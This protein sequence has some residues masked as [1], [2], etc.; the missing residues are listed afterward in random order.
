MHKSYLHYNYLRLIQGIDLT[1]QKCYNLQ[2]VIKDSI[3]NSR[4]N[5]IKVEHIIKFPN[6]GN[7]FRMKENIME[8]VKEEPIK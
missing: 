2:K 1:F 7:I 4:H 3:I 8:M 5:I 6:M